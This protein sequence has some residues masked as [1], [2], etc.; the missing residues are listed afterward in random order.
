MSK[1]CYGK[2]PVYGLVILFSFISVLAHSQSGSYNTTNWHFSNPQQFGFTIFDVDYLDNNTAIA[3]GSDGGIAKTTDGGRNWT[4]GPFTFINASGLLTKQ[5]FNDVHFVSATT[6]YAVGNAG[7]MAKS[8][9]GGSTWNLVMTPFYNT[10]KNINATWFLSDT[11]GYIGGQFNSSDSI[12][13][14]YVTNNGGASWDSMNAPIGGK[15][16]VGYVNN[17]NLAPLVWDVDSKGKEIQRIEFLDNNTGYIVGGGASGSNYFPRHPAVNTTT[18]LPNGTTTTTA[19]Q[20][21]SLV[22]KYSNGS[23]IDYSVSKERLGKNGIYNAAPNCSYRYASN[24]I[25]TQTYKAMHI[26]DANTVLIMSFNN[27]IVIKIKT[28]PGDQTP[29]INVPGVF[30][31]GIYELLNAPFPPNNNSATGGPAIPNPQVLSATNPYHIRKAANGKLMTV[32]NLGLLYTSVDTGRNWVRE[33]SLPQNQPYSSFGTWA[34]DI[35]PNG[36]VL[37]MGSNGVTADSIPGSPWYSNY[38]FMS[39][40]GTKIDFADCNN[41]LVV[42]GA[43]FSTT[44]NGGKAWNETVRQ[45]FANLFITIN[46]GAYVPGDPTKA[47]LVTSAGTIYKSDNVNAVSPAVPLL[48]P[49]FT[50]STDQMLDIATVG[51]DSVWVCGY[52]GFSVAAASRSPKV[53]RSTNGG[54]TW[55]TYNNFHTGSTFQNFRLIEFPSRLVG[56]VCGTRDTIW[57][58]SDGGNTWVKL[59]LPT[60]GITPQITYTDMY[61]L[62]VNTVFLT[63]NGFPRKVLFRTT[64]GGNTW[65]DISSNLSTFG[66]GNFNSVVFHDLNNGYVTSPGGYLFKTTDGG[67]SWTLDIAP[68]NNLFT[69]AEF[70][71]KKVPAG[72][73][74]GNRRLFITGASIGI[75]GHILEYGNAANVNVSS[76]ETLVSSCSN[77]ANG[78]VTVTATGGIPP[79]SYSLDGGSFQASNVF[80]NVSAG[81]HTLIVKDF[82]CGLISKTVNVPIRT[83]PNVNAGPDK[84]IVEGDQVMIT[85]ASSGTPANILWT[86][87]GGFVSGANSFTPVINPSATTNYVLTVTDINGCAASDNALITVIPNCIKVM[88]AFTPNNDGQNDRWLVTDGN[89]C[90]DRIYVA[91]YNRYGNEVYHNDNYQNNWDGTYNGKPVA[92]GTY[93]YNVSFRTITGKMISVKGD[94]TILR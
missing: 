85:G 76:S 11:K 89:P 53:F 45:D 10:G 93:Y 6:V 39:G 88:N 94:V 58:T 38:K 1:N 27:N 17:P 42:G 41:G 90:T 8:T 56:Y 47:Y 12:P 29:N 26:I 33:F 86:S 24:S 48:D 35:A 60:P 59:P 15:T 31:N 63:G 68:S 57:K 83:S 18:C 23:L 32:V 65:Q 44:N 16:V 50:L 51:N 49:K 40:G 71:P 19:A 66:G 64:D 4:Y 43:A 30:E 2:W 79:Y 61:A 74:F 55:T 62:D 77:T 91:V 20:D 7:C 34:I 75:N 82:A 73:A 14:L 69:T 67:S 52:S 80:N 92:D 22:W 78:R 46:S 25:H 37:T 84:T 13:K 70:A 5:T 54:L 28:A 21:A 81:P 36:K 72:T 87:S 3:V 9:D